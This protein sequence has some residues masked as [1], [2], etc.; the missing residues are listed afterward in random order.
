MVPLWVHA[1]F[2]C[3]KFAHCEGFLPLNAG[4]EEWKSIVEEPR[5]PLR[6][7]EQELVT[8]TFLMTT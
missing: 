2:F 6:G 8:K 7:H 1:I 4:V 3:L 5:H